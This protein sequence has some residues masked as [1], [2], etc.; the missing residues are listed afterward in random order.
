MTEKEEK[1]RAIFMDIVRPAYPN[2]TPENVVIDERIR[3]SKATDILDALHENL[4]NLIQQLDVFTI[5]GK[6]ISTN[7][8]TYIKFE[9][10]DITHETMKSLRDELADATGYHVAYG[11]S[12]LQF[13]GNA[14]TLLEKA[15]A[16]S[17]THFLQQAIAPEMK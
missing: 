16:P 11:S 1:L 9:G 14:K 10:M 15:D 2:V 6:E 13:C 12:F 8:D 7:A 3:E 5:T 4:Q 17:F